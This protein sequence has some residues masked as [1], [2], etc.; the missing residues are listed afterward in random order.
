ML[1]WKTKEDGEGAVLRGLLPGLGWAALFQELSGVGRET[2]VRGAYFQSP[3]DDETPGLLPGRRVSPSQ[4]PQVCPQVRECS[5]RA[6]A[7]PVGSPQFPWWAQH[8]DPAPCYLL[9]LQPVS[10][11]VPRAEWRLVPLLTRP[12]PRTLLLPVFYYPRSLGEDPSRY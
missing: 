3:E 4:E 12:S 11:F 8:T 9:Q 5:G 1:R 2:L 7:N 10:S 6:C